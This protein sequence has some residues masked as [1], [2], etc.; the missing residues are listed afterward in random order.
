VI[1]YFNEDIKLPKLKRR[2][3]SNWIKS[4]IVNHGFKIGEINY[5]FCSDEYILNINNQYLKHDYYT[6]IITF[7]YNEGNLISSDIYISIDTVTKNAEYYKVN[8]INELNRVMIHGVLH[9]LG[10]DDKSEKEKIVMRQQEDEALQLL[11]SINQ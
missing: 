10:F 11:T 3:Y 8:F 7:N 5:I 2:I 6:D 1:N 4:I 9:L